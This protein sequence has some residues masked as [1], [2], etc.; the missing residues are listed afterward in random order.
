MLEDAWDAAPEGALTLRESLRTLEKEIGELIRTGQVQSV[1]KNSAN[2]SYA[3]GQ[4]AHTLPEIAI[5]WRDLLNLYARCREVIIADSQADNEDNIYAE[6]TARCRP[7]YS[8]RPDIT[9][10]HRC[11]GVL[12]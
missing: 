7:V 6:M 9:N 4:T 8:R 12:A 5:G 1:G 11:S 10:I 2:Q 3:F